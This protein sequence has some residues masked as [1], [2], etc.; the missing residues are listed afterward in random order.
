MHSALLVRVIAL[1]LL[2]A[3]L[4][5][6]VLGIG[7]HGSVAAPIGEKLDDCRALLAG[8]PGRFIEPEVAGKSD[9]GFARIGDFKED[10]LRVGNLV[11]GFSEG[12]V[13]TIC[14]CLP[15]QATQ[16]ERERSGRTE[17]QGCAAREFRSLPT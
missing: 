9:R 2:A 17:N 16:R 4:G 10:V 12:G 13:R 7:G 3:D 5:E 1:R 8:R 15:I 6:D 14:P 11:P